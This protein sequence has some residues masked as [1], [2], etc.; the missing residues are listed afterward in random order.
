MIVLLI[1]AVIGKKAGWFGKPVSVKVAVEN[2]EKR[3]I[4]ET[5]TAN[6]KIQPEKEVKIS[7]DVSGEIVELTVKEGDQ[8]DKGQLL[9]RI[10]PDIY[11]SQKDRSLAALSS[12]RARLT[13]SEAQFTEADLSFKR[14]KQLFEEQTISESEYEKA[15]ASYSVSKAEVDAAKYAVISAEASLKEANENLTKT[16]I[17]S[18]MSG[19][20]SMLLVERGERVAGTNLMAG[21]ELLRVAD[22]SRME[23]QVQVNENDIVRVNTGDTALIEVD[24]Y[25]NHD[26]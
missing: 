18:P 26:F 6:G 14:S 15:E 13:Q 19:T 2:A 11:I 4:T 3:T 1:F 16:S 22:L 10:K 20:V 17:Y 23:A 25:L 7:P 8:V 21:T 9:I 12:A 5:I 24:A